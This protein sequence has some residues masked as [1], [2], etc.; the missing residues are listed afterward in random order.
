M[1][2]TRCIYEKYSFLLLVIVS[3]NLK[4]VEESGDVFE[5]I[6]SLGRIQ[7]DVGQWHQKVTAKVMNGDYTIQFV[8]NDFY[9]KYLG[10]GVLKPIIKERFLKNFSNEELRLLYDGYVA[11]MGGSLEGMVQYR[12]LEQYRERSVN[13]AYEAFTEG[14]KSSMLNQDEFELSVKKHRETLARLNSY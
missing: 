7:G 2:H 6:W 4:A 10:F 11:G 12:A 3:V 8:V 1:I 9:E 5:S 13:I 14:L